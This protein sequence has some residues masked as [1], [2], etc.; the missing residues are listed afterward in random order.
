M[1]V[2]AKRI[3]ITRFIA[4]W[5]LLMLGLSVL[6]RLDILKC[7]SANKLRS[8]AQK[9]VAELEAEL[10]TELQTLEHNIGQLIGVNAATGVAIGLVAGSRIERIAKACYNTDI[11]LRSYMEANQVVTT[12]KQKHKRVC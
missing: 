7:R 11:E 9:S 2:W 5:L 6:A 3:D 8:N 10:Q 12:T 4:N 1:R